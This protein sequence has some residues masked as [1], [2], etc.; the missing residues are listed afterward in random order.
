MDL[1]KKVYRSTAIGTIKIMA[2][3]IIVVLFVN[4]YLMIFSDPEFNSLSRKDFFAVANFHWKYPY[5]LLS[6]IFFILIPCYYFGFI[7][8]VS[9][10]ENG[11]IV[12]RGAPFLNSIIPYSVIKQYE[13]I[14]S[15]LFISVKRSDTNEDV[16]FSI[17]DVDRAVSIFD[18]NGIKG[19]LHCQERLVVTMNKKLMIFL[20]A[21]GIAV[22]LGQSFG[23]SR[24]L[25]R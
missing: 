25:F 15:K 20:I 14:H 5:D 6:Y 7:R 8:G 11:I 2:V 3:V 17:S 21:I 10:Y 16:L 12:N 24:F 13:I 9:F 19:D 22:M 23:L 4:L 18:Q 1:G